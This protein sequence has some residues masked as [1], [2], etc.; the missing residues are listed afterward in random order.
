MAYSYWWMKKIL[1]AL[2]VSLFMV[3]LAAPVAAHADVNDFVIERFAADYSISNAD[4]QGEMKVKETIAVNFSGQNHGILRAIPDSYKN[5]SLQMSVGDIMLDGQTAQWSKYSSNGNTVLKIGD[6]DNTITGRHT[7]EINYTVRNVISFYD[8]YDELFWDINGDQWQQTAEEVSV[9]LHFTDEAG[10]VKD[11]IC[12]TGVF[13]STEQSCS[14]EVRQDTISVKTT[15]ALQGYETMSMVVAF[16]PD[17]FEPSTWYETASEYGATVLKFLVPFLLIAGTAF[18]HWRRYGR[19]P[20]G[21]RV[22]VPEYEAPD[23]LKPVEAGTVAD[24]RTDN[25]DITATIIDLAVRGY[26]K[27]IETTHDRKFLK[28]TKTYSLRLENADYNGLNSFEK[29]LMQGIFSKHTKG[30]EIDLGMLKYKLSSTATALQRDVKKSLVERGYF[31]KTPLSTTM[32][33]AGLLF[34]EFIAAIIMA[35][36]F[37]GAAVILG[38]AAGTAAAVIFI[39]LLPSRTPQGVAAKESIAGLKMYLEV[40]ESERIK[41]LQSPDAPY[42][43]RSV[44]PKKTVELF[45]KLLPFA[46]IL[47]VEEQWAK[48]FEH[49]YHAQPDWYQGDGRTFSAVY[50]AHSLNTGVQSNINAAFSSPSSS[51]SSGFSGGGSSGG[52]GGGGGGGGW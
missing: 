40:A 37:Q 6:P 26:I 41:K 32:R 25:R 19:D 12:F 16:D 9:V 39:I 44:E 38:I 46:V 1:A 24:F 27:I 47:G 51:G 52:G 14:V 20:K 22:I 48:K 5:H 2:V 23:G 18:I 13:G 35:V 42:A 36:I 15:R 10:L 21:K 7:Y 50:L 29:T 33:F 8:G 34:L 28:D 30:E 17:Y 45:E 3:T 31:R 49:I 43:A 11:P 4:R